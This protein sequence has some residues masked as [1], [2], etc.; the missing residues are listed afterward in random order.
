MMAILEA[1]GDKRRE[2]RCSRDIRW[3][4]CWACILSG[5]VK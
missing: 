2:E 3:R 1:S 5:L 4:G